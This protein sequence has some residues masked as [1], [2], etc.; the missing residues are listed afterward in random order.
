MTKVLKNER[1]KTADRITAATWLADRGWG[2]P[3]QTAEIHDGGTSLRDQVAALSPEERAQLRQRVLADLERQTREDA[4][5]SQVQ[6][7]LPPSSDT[8]PR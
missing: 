8:P 3:A 5:G 4:E 6:P 1:E 2:R 7:A